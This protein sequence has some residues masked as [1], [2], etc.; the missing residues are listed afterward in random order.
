MAYIPGLVV[1]YDN[2]VYLNSDFTIGQTMLIPTPS[3][4]GIVDDDYWAIPVSTGVITG[5]NYQSTTPGSVVQPDGSNGQAFHVVRIVSKNVPDDWY[6]LGNSTE[7]LAASED[8]E[9]CTSPPVLMPTTQPLLAPCQLLCDTDANG[10]YI[11]VWGIPHPDTGTYHINGYVNG[12]LQTQVT[13]ANSAGIAAALN[14]NGG[15]AAVG[16]WTSV[17]DVL[18]V[19][20]SAGDGTTVVCIVITLV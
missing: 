9:C 15:W 3:S 19:T 4:G 8:V 7:Y 16:V 5:F 20:Q 17:S 11:G 12:V 6:V 10:N 13:S 18:V 1:Q 2:D 14:G